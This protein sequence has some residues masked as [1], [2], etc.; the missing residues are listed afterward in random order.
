MV[1]MILVIVASTDGAIML[2]VVMDRLHIFGF[3]I[4]DLASGSA[5]HVSRHMQPLKKPSTA[6]VSRHVQPLKK[7]VTTSSLGF[8]TVFQG[9]AG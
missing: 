1:V 4:C 3:G 7:T 2:M 5:A 8:R 6:H 9:L